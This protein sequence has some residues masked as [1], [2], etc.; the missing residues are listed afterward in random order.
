M[1]AGGTRT[2]FPWGLEQR[3]ICV[4]IVSFNFGLSG[5]LRPLAATA[6][7]GV[8]GEGCT[9]PKRLVWPEGL[10]QGG[11]GGSLTHPAWRSGGGA[12]EPCTGWGWGG[13]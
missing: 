5:T 3:N 9:N 4:C 13:A 12:W 1:Q 6:I 11:V 10:A 8:K 7:S 2:A